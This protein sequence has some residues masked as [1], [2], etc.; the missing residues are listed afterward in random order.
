MAGRA[1]LK[2]L[3]MAALIMW[4]GIPVPER[5]LSEASG[6]YALDPDTERRIGR[7]ISGMS[8]DDK[9][10]QM[11]IPAMRTWNKEPVTDLAKVPELRDILSA[12][13]YGGIILFG[14]NIKGNAETE[15]LLSDL[16]GIVA[17]SPNRTLRI[18]YF[19]AVDEEGGR[20][21]R[22][23]QGTRMTGSMAVGATPH[24][25]ENAYLTGSVIGEE[26]RSLGFNVNLAPV[27]D[28]SS[29]P[30]NPVIGA[31]SFSDDAETVGLLGSAYAR[32][33]MEQGIIPVF[34]HYPGHGD[35]VTDSHRSLPA[36]YGSRE[37]LMNAELLPF[38]EATQ[39]G[40]E[41]IMTAH[42]ACP[43][44]DEL[45]VYGDGVT[46]G[47]YPATMST[48]LIRDLLR[49]DLG[50]DGV[51]L[52]DALEM[53]AVLLTGLVP[54]EPESLEYRINL[55]EKVIN[56]GADMLLLPQDLRNREVG[57]FYDNY[58][59]GI[60]RLVSAGSVPEDR[61][62]ESVR[63]ILRL[64]VKYGIFDIRHPGSGRPF[65]PLAEDVFPEAAGAGS[66]EHHELERR[67]AGEAITLIKNRDGMLP[68]TSAVKSAVIL[69]RKEEELTAADYAI[70]DLR[71]RGILSPETRVT[72]FYYLAPENGGGGNNG[73][74]GNSVN[75]SQL[76]YT[77]EMRE[78]IL[79][80]DAVIGYSHLSGK[81]L[82]GAGN[83]SYQAL[84]RAI[85]DVHAGG[86]R[87]VLISGNL[88][89][90]AAFYPEADAA[91]LSYMGAGLDSAPEKTGPAGLEKAAGNANFR[92]ALGKIFGEGEFAGSLP[93]NIPEILKLPGGTAVY[94]PRLLYRRGFREQSPQI[95][96]RNTRRNETGESK[97][98]PRD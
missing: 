66:R 6:G 67:M 56:A 71:A 76:H 45:Q 94:G 43:E 35:T 2:A 86:G 22:L 19:L 25:P 3:I 73:N 59:A 31:R 52:S 27:V 74:K 9:I 70:K 81:E 16:R 83:I 14:I 21:M 20:V 78:E 33:L 41:M 63:R 80:A 65:L 15:K 17:G 37:K 28:V 91:V 69:M 53:E 44:A 82:P 36:V 98:W 29:N 87:F 23:R 4:P 38:R 93:V 85:S 39:N 84:S 95:R 47:Y 55:A 77:P 57:S 13:A 30:G 58:I 12:H 62:N 46:R 79:R 89:Y 51:V 24:A 5:S 75:D 61:I 72:A 40:A 49:K 64:K 1:V 7:L 8:L 92:A 90:D 32:G 88:P 54:G 18:P 34:K 96:S 97:T 60:G 26:L 42:I 11:I 10:S 48:V 50:F 68:L